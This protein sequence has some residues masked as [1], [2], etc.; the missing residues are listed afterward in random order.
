VSVTTAVTAAPG[1][2]TPRPHTDEGSRRRASATLAAAAAVSIGLALATPSLHITFTDAE[3]RAATSAPAAVRAD[4]PAS[5]IESIPTT[6]A[7][8]GLA[9]LLRLP[10][11][12]Q[13]AVNKELGAGNP[14]F[15]VRH[16][17]AGL[18]AGN[19]AQGM[20][21]TF[22]VAGP[23]LTRD[24][25]SMQLSLRGIGYGERLVPVAAAS[26]SVTGPNSVQ[27]DRGAVV[28][29]YDNGPLGLAQSFV[30]RAAPSGVR[31]G[32]LTLALGATQ[33]FSAKVS[34]SRAEAVF[35]KAGASVFTYRGLH[36]TDA[37]H[38]TLP[39]RMAA[40]PTGLAIQVD[41]RAA[42]YPIT[43]DPFA[44]SGST[45]G[46]DGYGYAV[47][48]AAVPNLAGGSPAR[49]PSSW[50]AIGDPNY[51]NGTTPVGRVLLYQQ[52]PVGGSWNLKQTQVGSQSGAKLGYS[53]DLSWSLSSLGLINPMPDSVQFIVAIGSP[54]YDRAG[55]D[56]GVVFFT[57]YS[58]WSGHSAVDFDFS[59]LL[60]ASDGQAGDNLGA[61]VAVSAGRRDIGSG[62][63]GVIVL[64]GS[65]KDDFGTISNS[66]S[67]RVWQASNNLGLSWPATVPHNASLGLNPSPSAG[68]SPPVANNLL[69][70]SV[71]LSG[72]GKTAVVGVPGYDGTASSQGSGAVFLAPG[73]TWVSGSPQLVVPIKELRAW[74]PVANDSLG[75]SVAISGDGNTIALGAPYDDVTYSDQ[76]S[77]RVYVKPGAG[78]GA[79]SISETKLLSESAGAAGD[80]F[81][82]SVS[83]DH[84]GSTMVA[85]APKAE[86]NLGGFAADE[87]AAFVYDRPASGWGAAAPAPQM[88]YNA[89]EAANDH[90]GS[91]V[92][93]DSYSGD[94][95]DNGIT[96]TREHI[97]VGIQR[98][99]AGSHQSFVR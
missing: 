26:P 24:G 75:Q 89:S 8:S 59:K 60:Y 25:Q 32:G 87:G 76:G 93:I 19:P 42:T 43:I 80:W 52:M 2:G 66:G 46:G 88:L 12:G 10:V 41:D 40:S 50:V 31:S 92:S 9:G 6:T 36:V 33:G 21:A 98:P 90:F 14:A 13:F 71:D 63:L 69:G 83:I 11:S 18:T 68:F 27:Y 7:A 49:P 74:Q 16:G 57:R 1:W 78:W 53:V 20:S 17:G 5:S 70:T 97:G 82:A 29:R 91:S 44:S 22:G 48:A 55:T 84:D 62:Y 72:D 45:S 54:N 56:E 15:A 95:D 28:E 81:G 96:E 38:R 47:S 51:V 73:G 30:L 58:W 23:T 65:P 37:A 85:G 77:V 35:S 86:D 99:N 64:G 39:A 79:S 3:G 67:A 34:S 61:S 94:Y 4:V